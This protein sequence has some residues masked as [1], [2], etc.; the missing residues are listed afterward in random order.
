[1]VKMEV[2][3][4]AN[5]VHTLLEHLSGEIKDYQEIADVARKIAREVSFTIQEFDDM[6]GF[7]I[8]SERDLINMA[9]DLI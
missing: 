3:L 9:G 7:S 6:F 8:Y 4:T 1:M 5:D 2:Y